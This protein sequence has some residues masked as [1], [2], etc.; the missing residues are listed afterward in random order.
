MSVPSETWLVM[1]NVAA[2]H[3]AGLFALAL[4]AFALAHAALGLV[5]SRQWY[6]LPA[7]AGLTALAGFLL[8]PLADANT[9]LDLRMKL[10]GYEALTL[11][12]IAQFLLLAGAWRLG[13]RL[14]SAA[15]SPH[16]ALAL[17]V[18]QTVPAPAVLVAMLLLEQAW[19]A[20]LPG[21][22][23][24]AV[25]R[26][27]GLI[28][29]GMLLSLVLLTSAAPRRWLAPLHH[30]LS[31]ALVLACMLLPNLQHPLP[32]PMTAIAWDS[33]ALGWKAALGFAAVVGIGWLWDRARRKPYAN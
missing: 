26:Q 19:L 13:F 7:S 14:D 15:D 12:C 25:G 18:V 1:R 24:E 4:S 22:R 29:A 10:T 30:L 20:D 31:A 3:P 32:Q 2:A 6:I 16:T 5:R 27:V 9:A 11:L 23:P 8:N 28:A 17:A 21:A 33:L